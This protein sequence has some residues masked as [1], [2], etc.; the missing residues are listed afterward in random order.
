MIA[1]LVLS[2]VPIDAHAC[3]TVCIVRDAPE[4]AEQVPTNLALWVSPTDLHTDQFS[5]QSDDAPNVLAQVQTTE[6]HNT[7]VQTLQLKGELQ[8]N[9][10]YQLFGATDVWNE[11]GSSR[12]LVDMD[13]SVSTLDGPL[14]EPP[15][16]VD[17]VKLDRSR[18]N[19]WG[20]TCDAWTAL[21]VAFSGSAEQGGYLELQASEEESFDRNTAYAVGGED[22]AFGSCGHNLDPN[23]RYWWRVRSV[24]AAGNASAW[25]DLTRYR[26]AAECGCASTPTLPALGFMAPLLALIV[27]RRRTLG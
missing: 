14:T 11:Q 10:T 13:L 9:T 22:V 21:D 2:V 15:E 16:F 19:G 1:L 24:D 20:S 3:T 4:P 17:I 6:F 7:S 26:T 8:P 12:R 25:S 5:F 27:R 23:T 18:G